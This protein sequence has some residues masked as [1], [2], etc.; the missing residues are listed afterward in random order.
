[1]NGSLQHQWT[2]PEVRN[3]IVNSGYLDDATLKGDVIGYKNLPNLNNSDNA[4]ADK[5]AADA[6]ATKN[7]LPD[8][9]NPE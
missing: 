6:E 9:T 7:A 2:I 3:N 8:Q 4:L 5:N 1:M